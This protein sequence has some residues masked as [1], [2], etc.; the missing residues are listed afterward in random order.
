MEELFGAPSVGIEEMIA[1]VA[2]WVER[3]GRSLGKATKFG[4][5]EGR[6]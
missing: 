2:E 5:R 6:F 1:R 3:G 4:E